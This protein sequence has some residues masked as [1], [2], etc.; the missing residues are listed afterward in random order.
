MSRPFVFKLASILRYRVQKE[1]QAQM[2]FSLAKS[3]YERQ[4]RLVSEL[5]SQI[6]ECDA[7][8]MTRQ[9]ITQADLWLWGNYKKRLEQDHKEAEILLGNYARDVE[10]KR[11]RLIVCAKNKKLLE[12]LQ[13][14]QAREHEENERT[15]EQKEFDETATLRFDKTYS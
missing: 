12:K 15:L 9:S 7:R 8:F 14:N 11:A 13:S 2:A 6:K 5:A 4:G 1:E 3:L 10:K